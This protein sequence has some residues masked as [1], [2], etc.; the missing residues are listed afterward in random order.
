MIS[1][2]IPVLNEAATIEKLL[3]HLTHTASKEYSKD[4]SVVDGGSTDGTCEIVTRFAEGSVL[5]VHLIKAPKGRARQLN[6]GARFATGEIL[7]FLHADSFPPPGFDAL[8]RKEVQKGNPAGCFKMKFDSDHWWLQLAGFFTKFN[9]KACRG[10]DQSLFVTRTLFEEIG[11]FNER[12]IIYED[13]IFIQQL[14]ARHTFVVIQKELTTSARLYQTQGVWKVQYHFL[15]IYLKK[16][17][18]ADAEALHAY[19]CKHL[20]QASKNT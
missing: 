9:F 10:G 18:G 17:L 3:K 7:Y 12:Y 19:Y 1:I 13:N 20:K 5:P 2:V 8:I 15:M 16:A 11:G 6:A 14:Y 4:I